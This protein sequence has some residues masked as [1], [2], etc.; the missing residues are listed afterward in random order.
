M[1]QIVTLWSAERRKLT[2]P[3]TADQTFKVLSSEPLT[4][5]LPQNCRHVITWS[6][7][8]FSTYNTDVHIRDTL[9]TGRRKNEAMSSKRNAQSTSRIKIYTK[10]EVSL[11]ADESRIKHFISIFYYLYMR[12]QLLKSVKTSS[13]WF[14]CKCLLYHLF[15]LFK[16]KEYALQLCNF[17]AQKEKHLLSAERQYSPTFST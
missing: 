2:L 1:H 14:E 5:R 8:P 9:N 17:D 4:I 11:L 10:C 6:S 16:Q 13:R 15:H 7:C 12:H 3:V